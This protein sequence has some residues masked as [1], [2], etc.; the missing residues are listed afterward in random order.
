MHSTT[1]CW[2]LAHAP[3]ATENPFFCKEQKRRVSDVLPMD[4]E[5]VRV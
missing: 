2:L 1:K 3:D 4:R 5:M